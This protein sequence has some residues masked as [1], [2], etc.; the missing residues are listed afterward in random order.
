MKTFYI[1]HTN[2]LHSHFEH[3]PK[4]AA[5]LKDAR[6]RH[7]YRE[8]SVLQFDI[9]DHADRFHPLTEGTLGRGNIQLLNDVGYNAVTIGNNEGITFSKYDLEHLYDEATFPVLVANLFDLEGHRP[10][11]MNDYQI[12]PLQNGLQ[13]GVIGITIPFTA[14][15]KP[16]GWSVQ[17]PMEILPQLI[18]EVRKHADIVVLLSHMGYYNDVEFA[19]Q[20]DG[21]DIILGAHTHHLLKQGKN[22]KGTTIIQAGKFGMYAGQMKVTYDENQQMIVD[23]DAHSVPI[24]R[25]KEDETAKRLLADLNHEGEKALETPVADLR[26]SLA[27]PWFESSPF[28]ELLARGIRE[29][30]E[31]EISMVNAGVLLEGLSEGT[32]TKGDLHRICPHPINPCKINIR[33]EELRETVR[34]AFTKKL[35]HLELKGFGFR[36]EVLGAFIFDGVEVETVLLEDG[37]HH[38]RSM[39]V[40]GEAIDPDRQYELA[41]L[42]TFTFGRLFPAIAEAKDKHFYIPEMLRDILAWKIKKS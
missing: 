29:W 8:E 38:V 7:A 42:D 16:L 20:L 35:T 17:E 3:W 21:I 24:D 39:T 14:F 41:T 18:K 1:Y 33:G 36:G 19:E 12:Y 6:S 37:E 2:D 25:Y 9:G 15:Y 22:V 27:A 11:G 10:H 32:V 5:Y 4:I 40:Q 30:C 28:S 26:G 23:C 34:Q 31:A 13:V